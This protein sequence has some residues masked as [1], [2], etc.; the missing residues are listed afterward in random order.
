MRKKIRIKDIA[1]MSGVSV[2][3][4]D[5]VLHG[6][7]KVSKDSQAAVEAVL[8]RVNY[9]PNI[10]L[11][12][13]SLKKSFKIIVTTPKAK[14]GE[15][16]YYILSGIQSAL[17][18]FADIDIK[19]EYF[20]YDQYDVY[21]CMESFSKIKDAKPDAVIIGPTFADAS[22]EFCE[23]LSA[24]GIPYVFVD[25]I[26]EGTIPLSAYATD[27]FSCG[28]LCGRLIDVIT[29]KNF[30]LGVFQAIRVGDESAN[31][32]I[33]RKKGFLNYVK[34]HCPSRKIYK[35]PF[36]VK[37]RDVTNESIRNF[38]SLHE[39]VRGVL[40]LNSH[41]NVIADSLI[42]NSLDNVKLVCF[43][44]TEKNCKYLKEGRIS[45]IL[46]QRPENQGYEAIQSIVNY[47]V[48]K[49]RPRQVINYMPIDIFAKENLN[50]FR[51][52]LREV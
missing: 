31:N 16:W 5:R 21:S 29:P 45:F 26:I 50:Y 18:K 14:E 13:I 48:C 20:H 10:H 25:S 39:N 24:N 41:G 19:C 40:T 30:D 1:E 33:R 35:I 36:S 15:Y 4:V 46:G 52:N 6:R 11:S 7:G 43:D 8:K 12:A 2:G 9:Q 49:K 42:D 27:P 32:T 17:N 3:T 44:M 22:L 28:Q 47:L 37:D 38:F 51:P 34:N 23:D